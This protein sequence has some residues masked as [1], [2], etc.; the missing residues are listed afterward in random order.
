[1]PDDPTPD[2]LDAAWADLVVAA[3]RVK[4]LIDED[5]ATLPEWEGVTIDDYRWADVAVDR[6]AAYRV[7]REPNQEG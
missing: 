5:P 1:M 4:R 6:V 7:K 2:T 3:E